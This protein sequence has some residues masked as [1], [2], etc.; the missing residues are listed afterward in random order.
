MAAESTFAGRV[1]WHSVCARAC[2]RVCACLCV[3]VKETTR[4]VQHFTSELIRA[5]KAIAS[6]HTARGVKSQLW[7][8]RAGITA[9]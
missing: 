5:R 1:E 8:T 2:V 7:S 9:V 6:L 3:R 4:H